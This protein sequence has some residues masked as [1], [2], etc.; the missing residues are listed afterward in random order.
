M[1]TTE[2]VTPVT[3]Y[4]QS[5]QTKLGLA[6]VS[7]QQEDYMYKAEVKIE[8]DTAVFKAKGI[9]S[10]PR[11]AFHWSYGVKQVT[12]DAWAGYVSADGILAE[13]KPPKTRKAIIITI[14][15]ALRQAQVDYDSFTLSKS[16]SATDKVSMSAVKASTALS[17]EEKA[18]MTAL[19]AKM[20]KAVS[21]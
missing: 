5:R 20:G 13:T 7:I 14:Q 12:N 15:D 2:V 6:I 17:E 19:F 18:T 8:C 3:I 4:T 10:S 1:D 21:A 11:E 9:F 16:S